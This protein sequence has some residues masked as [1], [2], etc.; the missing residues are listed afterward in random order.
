M[1][2]VTSASSDRWSKVR[3]LVQTASTARAFC[4]IKIN[5]EDNKAT[6]NEK[7]STIINELGIQV[8]HKAGE[9]PADLSKQGN[10]M[11]YS[12]KH[13]KERASLHADPRVQKAI[14][15]MW[16]TEV[17]GLRFILLV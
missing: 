15:A 3:S 13:L 1:T 9:A 14:R 16:N 8:S 7:L 12:E 4:S 6:V 17:C 5:F 11:L 2:A 10:P